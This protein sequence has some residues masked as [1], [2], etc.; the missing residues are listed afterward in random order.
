MIKSVYRTRE[1]LSKV[2]SFIS[3]FT[4]ARRSP[5]EKI[6][7]ERIDKKHKYRICFIISSER[8]VVNAPLNVKRVF[9]RFSRGLVVSLSHL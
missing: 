5:K 9:L 7:R 6:K 2:F 1:A 8:G 4:T 3:F